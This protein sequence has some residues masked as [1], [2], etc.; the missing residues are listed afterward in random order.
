MQKQAGGRL[1]SCGIAGSIPAKEQSSTPKSFR[2]MRFPTSD[3]PVRKKDS[4]SA[5]P[6]S[7]SP[8]DAATRKPDSTY[9][10]SERWRNRQFQCFFCWKCLVIAMSRYCSNSLPLAARSVP[11]VDNPEIEPEV[12]LNLP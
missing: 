5:V 8:K 10:S 4:A 3:F 12:E 1:N 2:Q 9:L 6:W 7:A 11:M